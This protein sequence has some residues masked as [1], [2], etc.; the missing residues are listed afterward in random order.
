[1]ILIQI[2]TTKFTDDAF[3]LLEKEYKG[4]ISLKKE[5]ELL[6]LKSHRNAKESLSLDDVIDSGHKHVSEDYEDDEVII[7]GNM[8]KKVE[9]VIPAEPK[10]VR[11]DHKEEMITNRTAGN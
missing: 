8:S 11:Q 9:T 1:M 4:D 5:S 7:K 6:N 10:P 2:Q 3:H